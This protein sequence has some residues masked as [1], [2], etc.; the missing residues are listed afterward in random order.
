MNESLTKQHS[1]DNEFECLT[2]TTLPKLPH[3]GTFDKSY[4]NLRERKNIK[5]TITSKT[6][7]NHRCVV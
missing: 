5:A 6:K 3:V 4:T 1:I 2:I 7:P